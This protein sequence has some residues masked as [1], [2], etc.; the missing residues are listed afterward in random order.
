M[1]LN[2]IVKALSSMDYTVVHHSNF[3]ALFSFTRVFGRYLVSDHK[4]TSPFFIAPPA[5]SFWFHIAGNKCL[6]GLWSGHIFLF[7]DD[8]TLIESFNECF[9]HNYEY[10]TDAN[11][12][13][14]YTREIFLYSL[15]L[16]DRSNK[17]DGLQKEYLLISLEKIIDFLSAHNI[18]Y[19]I[20]TEQW[21]EFSYRDHNIC[22][23]IPNDQIKQFVLD[24]AVSFVNNTVN[25][26][27][28]NNDSG[29]HEIIKDF[30]KQLGGYFIEW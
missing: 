26:T 9:C 22:F 29:I 24:I 8:V 15:L 27:V 3:D 1:I 6:V 4:Y 7:D 13:S 18:E 17:Y 12:V 21:V 16:A 28:N 11:C 10:F 30:G 5:K 19:T 14:R 25:N 2:T 20:T 23:R